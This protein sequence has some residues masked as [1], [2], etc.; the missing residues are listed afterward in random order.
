MKTKKS[1]KINIEN[2]IGNLVKEMPTIVGID[3]CLK[4]DLL[5]YKFNSH[6][7]EPGVPKSYVSL[8]IF[9]FQSHNPSNCPGASWVY[10]TVC[11]I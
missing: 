11:C 5:R 8:D 1:T 9:L 10:L 3:L 2:L 6:F 7:Y 4:N